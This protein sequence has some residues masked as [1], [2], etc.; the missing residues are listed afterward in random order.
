[1][2]KPAFIVEFDGERVECP[3]P[4]LSDLV[5]FERQFGISATILEPDVT[6]VLDGNGK[7]IVDEDGNAVVKVVSE[8]R[9]EWVAFLLYRGLRKAGTIDVKVVAFDDDFLDRISDVQMVGAS[10]EDEEQAPLEQAPQP[11]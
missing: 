2:G 8:F 9:L 7:Q 11:G 6:P 3:E 1:M 5:A 4:G 10:K